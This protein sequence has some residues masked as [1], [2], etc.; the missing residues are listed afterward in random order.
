MVF[1]RGVAMSVGLRIL[2]LLALVLAGLAVFVRVVFVHEAVRRGLFPILRPLYKRVFNP[3]VLRDAARGDTRWGVLHHVGRRSGVAYDTPID[4]Q[5][6]PEGAVIALVYGASVDWCRNVLAAGGCTLT[7]SGQ[8]LAFT[9]PRVV[10]IS[11]AAAQLLPAKAEFW[12]GI[13]IEHLLSL[14]R[15]P[16]GELESSAIPPAGGSDALRNL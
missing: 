5:L 6:T 7:V 1:L 10:P 15:A 4:A 2:G 14:T 13:G 16:S 9:A 8:D 12:R 3:R 11:F